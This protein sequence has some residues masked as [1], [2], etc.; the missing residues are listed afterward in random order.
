MSIL[1]LVALALNS[2][3]TSKMRAFLT[4]LG[5]II[6]IG[7]VIA[8]V[9]VGNSLTGSLS[10]SMS[11]FGVNSIT[12]S[13]TQKSSSNS[14]GNYRLF[15]GSSP[16]EDDL[17]SESM[18]EEYRQAYGDYIDSISFTE[19]LSASSMSYQGT[20]S[21]VRISGVNEEAASSNSIEITTGRFIKDSDQLRNVCVI[22]DAMAEELFGY[23]DPIGKTLS[24]VFDTQVIDFYVVGLY[25]YSEDG[26]VS[27]DGST[28]YSVYIPLQAAKKINQSSEGFQ[29]FTVSASNDVSTTEFMNATEQFFQSFYTRND[30]Y[31][32]EASSMESMVETMTEMLS[33]V[34]LAI[35]AIAAISL[36][37]GGIGVMNIMLVSITERTREIG[38]RIALGATRNAIR[39]QFIVEAMVICLIGGCIG[40]AVGTGLSAVACALMGYSVKPSLEVIALAVLFSM[41]IG[42]FFGC[43]PAN[44]AAKMNPIDA[45]RYE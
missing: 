38:T 3:K 41:S 34:S 40:V 28:T 31:T 26:S 39:L 21:S 2:L 44:K 45:L 12:V 20:S 4:M 5:I 25:E 6:G 10:D 17:M 14:D 35:A 42:I 29:S 36:L 32:V 9:T 22:A 18:I 27:F 13:L 16:D 37:V 15:L 11:S 24:A 43:Y 7:S 30:S 33:T 23:T 1:D 8:I 19:S